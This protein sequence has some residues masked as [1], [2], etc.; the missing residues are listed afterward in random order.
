MADEGPAEGRRRISSGGPWERSV[1][2]SRAIV[3]GD[4]CYVS[5][6]TDAGPDGR[7]LHPGD[8]AAQARAAWE[9]VER[10]LAEAG[11]RLEDVVRTRTYVVALG[12]APAVAAVHGE[13]FGGIRPA[14]TLVQVA[15]LID[16]TL[17]VEVEA[18]ARRD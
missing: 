12:D 14:A 5:G 9:I 11:F 17:L 8:A 1:G 10:A 15:G 13:R 7:S 16:P 3:A 18:E 4:T 6:T 2:Y